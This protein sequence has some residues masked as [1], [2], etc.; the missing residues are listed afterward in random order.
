[1]ISAFVHDHGGVSDH[2]IGWNPGF[3]EGVSGAQAQNQSY[4][5]FS[6][7]DRV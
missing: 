5:E 6:Y 1:M 7:G 2:L 4:V 3:H